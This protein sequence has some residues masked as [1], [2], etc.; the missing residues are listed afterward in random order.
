MAGLSAKQQV[1]VLNCISNERLDRY[2]SLIPS[3]ANGP[4]VALYYTIQ[5][6]S[7]MFY[8]TI[9][10]LEVCLRNK[11]HEALVD[12]F[13]GR[14]K[15]ITLPGKPTEWYLWLP[16]NIHTQKEI[17]KVLSRASKEIRNRQL[18]PGDIISRLS[19]GS[20]CS[21]LEDRSDNK[22]RLFYWTGVEKSIF[23]NTQM[24]KRQIMAEIKWANALRNRLF[25]H[26]PIWTGSGVTSIKDAYKTL[27]NKHKRL[28]NIIKMMSPE[29]YK[30]YA[31]DYMYK[32]DFR[33]SIDGV[34]QKCREMV[35]Q[36]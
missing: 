21:I 18:I 23:P 2:K 29:L 12:F 31:L 32:R 25:H 30:S 6:A 35:N 26:E 17:K 36:K 16:R 10:I 24:K 22:D 33:V 5:S 13:T 15:S 7:S 3:S 9:Q 20:W 34:F 1:K 8:P 14:A 28:L 27:K 11:I 19:F 4:F